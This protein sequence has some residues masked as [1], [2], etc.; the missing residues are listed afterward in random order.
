[1]K[2]QGNLI[3]ALPHLRKLK[4]RPEIVVKCQA[5]M[6]D[7]TDVPIS[8]VAWADLRLSRS[9]SEDQADVNLVC[10][11]TIEIMV[12]SEHVDRIAFTDAKGREIAYLDI[13]LPSVDEGDTCTIHPS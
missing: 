8:T 11:F 9:T 5:I 1:M 10:P 3:N 13:L 12:E 7:T 2:F 6:R 4:N